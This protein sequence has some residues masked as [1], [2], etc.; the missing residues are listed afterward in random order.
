MNNPDIILADEPTGA[1]D[2]ETS[3]QIMN[4]LKEVSKEHLVIMVTHNP[5]LAETYAT[6]IIRLKDGLVTSDEERRP[7]EEEHATVQVIGEKVSEK[8]AKPVVKKEKKTKRKKMSFFTAL[9]LSLNNLM[10]KKGRTIL[11]AFA[12]AIGIIGIAMI[13]SV[14]TGVQNYIDSVESD[15]L[16]QYPLQ[17]RRETVDFTEMMQSMQENRKQKEDEEDDG[18]IKEISSNNMMSNI[19]ANMANEKTE[20]DMRAFKKF[21]DGNEELKKYVKTVEYGYATTLFAYRTDVDRKEGILRVNP[22]T[23]M[24]SIGMTGSTSS[25]MISLM[26]SAYDVWAEMPASTA[27]RDEIYEVIDGRFPEKKNEIVICVTERGRISDY[28]LYALGIY[29]SSELKK[30]FTDAMGGKELSKKETT[31][32]SFEELE[33]M[34]F[35]VLPNYLY[36]E[37]KSNGTYEDK[38]EDDAYVKKMLEEKGIDLQI[39]GIA[40]VKNG[41]TSELGLYG[42]VLYMTDL[43]DALI[44]DINASEIVKEQKA[45]PD[46]DVFTGIEFEQDEKKELTMEDLQAYIATLTEEEQQ[47][48]QMM[49]GAMKQQGSSDE[50]ILAA[51][52]AYLNK[53]TDATYD[54][55]LDLL[56]V[57]E[58]ENPASVYI[59]P[60]DFEAKEKITA[61]LDDYSATLE[62]GEELKYTDYVGLIMSSVTTIINAITYILIGFVGISLVV[63]SIMIGIITYISVMERTREIGILRA[64]GA[65]KQDIAR[66]FNAETL[67]IGFV[68]G[69]IGI[70]V[71]YLV[72]LFINPLILRLFDIDNIMVLGPI[73]AVIL[74]LLSMLLTLIGGFIPSRVAAKKDP[75]EALR[76][77]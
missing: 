39:V 54:G 77:E 75:V 68:S 33:K 32:F 18:T 1:L 56:G 60:K 38:S 46:V 69:L 31:K 10:T 51:F 63:S 5:E 53:E 74:V 22:A 49:I 70:G 57:A 43:M 41:G 52:S 27:M 23:V 11:T 76:T 25:S 29:D 30:M 7:E 64:I 19:I 3:V 47:T 73:P 24:D 42:G 50:D 55:N 8:V 36:Y 13:L 15:T 14:S 34:S 58:I 6:R 37:K 66:V 16:S 62:E 44:E 9:S 65:S 17:I 71:P 35:T 48:T 21:I 12:G 40:R 59:Y 67:I 45:N 28:T 72:S 61:I 4:I 26:G 20:N 2:T